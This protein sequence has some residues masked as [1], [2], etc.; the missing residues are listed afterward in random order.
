MSLLK[1]Q[2]DNEKETHLAHLDYLKQHLIRV[3]HILDFF[4]LGKKV[5]FMHYIESVFNKMRE[6]NIYISRVVRPLVTK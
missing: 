1:R 2:A 6:G 5:N 4:T 3:E